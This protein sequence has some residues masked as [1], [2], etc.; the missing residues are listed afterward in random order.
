TIASLTKIYAIE[1]DDVKYTEMK[2]KLSGK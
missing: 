2:K 1:G